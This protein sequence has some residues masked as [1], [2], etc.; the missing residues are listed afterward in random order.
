VIFISPELNNFKNCI[1][2][3][4]SDKSNTYLK[5]AT[6]LSDTGNGNSCVKNDDVYMLSVENIQKFFLLNRIFK[7]REICSDECKK[8]RC[9]NNF[10]HFVVDAFY[11][12]FNHKIKM[13][14]LIEF[15]YIDLY[16]KY[17]ISDSG[18]RK[19]DEFLSEIKDSLDDRKFDKLDNIFSKA[20][21]AYVK[22]HSY[23]IKLKAYETV[24]SIMPHMYREYCLKENIKVN[25]TK[26][27]KFLNENEIHYILVYDFNN[28]HKN[29]VR[30]RL[31]KIKQL[32][33]KNDA[34]NIKSIRDFTFDTVQV[35]RGTKGFN[36]LVKDIYVR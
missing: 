18:I 30:N 24:Y 28:P 33:C 21:D 34:K 17:E 8:K 14:F 25:M 6:E 12:N 9:K 22:E 16:D 27:K 5:S 1:D 3:F 26:F 10:E 11:A 4:K 36:N 15:K 23:R 13:F 2:F 20:K 35:I 31:K 7:S 29:E 32:P 19:M